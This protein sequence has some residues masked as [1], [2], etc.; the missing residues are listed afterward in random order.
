MKK[1]FTRLH[2]LL[3]WLPRAQIN[4]LQVEQKMQSMDEKCTFLELQNLEHHERVS[5]ITR[6]LRIVSD[7]MS[8]IVAKNF[9]GGISNQE[10][11]LSINKII[12][13]ENDFD[14]N[15][16]QKYHSKLTKQDVETL[17]VSILEIQEALS[18]SINFLMS[19]HLKIID[20]LSKHTEGLNTIV[21]SKK[22]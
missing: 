7:L 4:F 13:S 12:S 22:K 11:D 8:D 17:L 2:S 18:E 1:F 5:E 9:E 21:I 15:G 6:Q 10:S 3:R 16:E 20:L 19:D 14:A